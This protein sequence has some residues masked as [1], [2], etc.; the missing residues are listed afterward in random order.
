M[1][2][3][4]TIALDRAALADR[5]PVGNMTVD[6]RRTPWPNLEQEQVVCFEIGAE[7]TW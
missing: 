5:L 4:E 6:G 1:Y 2:M 7:G 3:V